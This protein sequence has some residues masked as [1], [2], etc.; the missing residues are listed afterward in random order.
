MLLLYTQLGTLAPKCHK[1]NVR[2]RLIINGSTNRNNTV[3]LN[4]S[5]CFFL[6]FSVIFA[7]N[8]CEILGV[9]PFGPQAVIGIENT[10]EV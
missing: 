4:K 1:T 5:L 9:L 8:V 3:L 6:F 10:T 7:F 2:G